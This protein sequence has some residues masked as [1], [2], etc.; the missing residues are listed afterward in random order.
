MPSWTNSI[1][2]GRGAGVVEAARAVLPDAGELVLAESNR[3]VPHR[4]GQLERS[5]A[6]VPLPDHRVAITYR[7]GIAVLQHERM[8]Y[9]HKH[10]G[11]A[12]FLE[13]ALNSTRG[14]VLALIARAA[15]AALA[16][17]GDGGGE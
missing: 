6:V 11:A 15:A 16:G 8:D 13:H 17:G 2:P 5:G 12:K 1:D 4:T 7:S 14:E 9:Q 3:H 10:G